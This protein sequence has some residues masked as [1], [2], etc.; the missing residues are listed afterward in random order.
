MCGTSAPS[1]TSSTSSTASSTVLLPVTEK[2]ASGCSC[3]APQEAVAPAAPTTSDDVS[4][5][6]PV[7][8]LTCGSCASRVSGAVGKITGVRE[9]RVD[10]VAGGTSTLHVT[11]ATPL[12]AGL[13]A[14][15]ISDAGYQLAS[16]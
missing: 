8:G 2:N 5:A 4:A 6:F 7:L 1:T 11:S 15:T 12:D 3:C 9:A 16:S 13:V 10:L 14:S